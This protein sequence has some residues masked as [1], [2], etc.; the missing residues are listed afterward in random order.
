[1]A[2]SALSLAN[3]D[4]SFNVEALQHYQQALGPLQNSLRNEQDLAS[5][6]AFLTH[7]VLLLYEVCPIIRIEPPC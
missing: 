7:L 2:I 4:S 1:M 6:G 3:S 5:N